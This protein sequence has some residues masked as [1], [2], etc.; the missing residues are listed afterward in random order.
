MPLHHLQLK[1]I[2]QLIKNNTKPIFYS[3]HR[4]RNNLKKNLF[5]PDELFQ[6][7]KKVLKENKKNCLE[8]GFGDGR[9]VIDMARDK[10]EI[11]FFCI[12]AYSKGFTNLFEKIKR[13]KLENIILLYGDAIE[14]IDRLFEDASIDKIFIFFPDPWP[15]TKHKK[16]RILNKYSINL[17]FKKLIQQGIFHFTTDNIRYAYDVRSLLSSHFPTK[18]NIIFSDNRGDGPI[19]KYE[20]KALLKKNIIYDLI[21]SN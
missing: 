17:F 9:S 6:R 16:R 2:F 11:N 13:E 20:K 10:S 21:V 8:I 14:I 15:K 18:N 12:E 19:T 5:N 4:S 1:E 7:A 3:S